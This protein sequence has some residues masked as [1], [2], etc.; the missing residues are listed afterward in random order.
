MRLTFFEFNWTHRHHPWLLRPIAKAVNQRLINRIERIARQYEPALRNAFLAAV[1]SARQAASIEAIANALDQLN[2]AAAIRAATAGLEYDKMRATLAE[3]VEAAGQSTINTVPP[4]GNMKAVFD[5]V[6]YHAVR[7]ARLEVGHMISEIDYNTK[8]GI[9]RIIEDAIE[10]G[11]NPRVTARDIK[12][13]IGLTEYQTNIV[14]NYE[15]KL[16]AAGET[17]IDGK[18][19]RYADKWL[20][21]RA[22]AIS[23]SE[24]L[25]AA[26]GGEQAAYLEAIDQGF[27]NPD[28]E[29]VWIVARDERTCEIC[30]PM[31][32]ME[33]NQHVRVGEYFTGADGTKV[34]HPPIHVQC[35]CSVGLKL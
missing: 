21:R 13:M 2:P 14:L 24:T 31:P 29:Q 23:R 11:G 27:L 19:Q 22:L 16:L 9:Q 33:E 17:D 15:N 1:R 12:D 28:V 25:R 34:K 32:Q 26:N 3:I 30:K 7:F 18:V 35:R 4:K 8:R 10:N 20:R 5:I 6:N